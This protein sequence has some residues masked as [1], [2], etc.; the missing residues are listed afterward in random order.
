M[1]LEKGFVTVSR[2]S[3]ADCDWMCKESIYIKDASKA[4]D[5][6]LYSVLYKDQKKGL[7]ESKRSLENKDWRTD[8]EGLVPSGEQKTWKI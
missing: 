8:T 7:E 5:E 3:Q 4:S 1:I 6:V 2:E